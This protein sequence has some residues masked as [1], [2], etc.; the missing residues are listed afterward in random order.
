MKVKNSISDFFH[1][2]LRTTNTNLKILTAFTRALT[3]DTAFIDVV[4]SDGTTYKIPSLKGLYMQIKKLQ[5]Q[6]KLV[7][8]DEDKVFVNEPKIVNNVSVPLTFQ[9]EDNFLLKYLLRNYNITTRLNLTNIVS[10][11]SE[12]VN[13][14]RLIIKEDSKWDETIKKQFLGKNLDYPT[15]INSLN[16]L[17]ISY[18]IDENIFDLTPNNLKAS[19]TFLLT[20]AKSSYYKTA[21]FDYVRDYTISSNIYSDFTQGIIIPKI[22]LPGDK[23]YN[24]ET[25]DIY[26]I[27]A[28]KDKL[29]S[30]GVNY[31]L[32]GLVLGKTEFKVYTDIINE[33]FVDIPVDINE[34]QF[35]FMKEIT[36]KN[37]Q[38]PDWGTCVSFRSNRLSTEV[39]AGTT[40]MEFYKSSVYS[41]YEFLLNLEANGLQF[42]DHKTNPDA[43]TT[44]APNAPVLASATPLFKVVQINDFLQDEQ[45]VNTKS[46]NDLRATYQNLLTEITSIQKNLTKILADNPG[47]LSYSG[48]D[49]TKLAIKTQATNLQVKSSD[50]NT[51]KTE[52]ETK[53]QTTNTLTFSNVIGKK[54]R[55]NVRGMWPVPQR[56]VLNGIEQEII[57]FSIQYRYKSKTKHTMTFTSHE[58]TENGSTITGTYSNWS[59]MKTKMKSKVLNKST[60]KYEW[61]IENPG[62]SDEININ[63]LSLPINPGEA[64]D[65]RIK[66]ICETGYPIA[67]LESDWSDIVT[68]DFPADL[69]D[70]VNQ[71]ENF[72]LLQTTQLKLN[73]TVEEKLKDA[74]SLYASLAREVAN[75]NSFTPFALTSLVVNH[76]GG[77]SDF[78][79]HYGFYIQDPKTNEYLN[80]AKYNYR[81]LMSAVG[82][83][84]HVTFSENTHYTIS[85]SPSGNYVFTLNVANLVN[86]IDQTPFSHPAD[87]WTFYLQVFIDSK[88]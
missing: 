34:F 72:D 60:N 78:D 20:E 35:I 81:S 3:E 31:I 9:Y 32:D 36:R 17:N 63:Q 80:L 5:E 1:E 61:K 23:L 10:K 69:E 6:K 42:T 79:T 74:N 62:N 25:D 18:R 86:S 29:V 65:I 12:K 77:A 70:L 44:L 39:N 13:I 54:T 21:E 47:I 53:L 37:T 40:L 85:V 16:A 19:G 14:R 67:P 52:I 8:L 41:Y 45:K 4:L 48:S 33:K 50:L 75:L 28:I 66:T 84:G 64:I 2:I 71:Y 15:L 55:F 83:G 76:T 22:L 38:A 58:Y 57:Q 49:T 26:E 43:N 88:K 68:I 24:V 82:Y 11:F 87:N 56:K 30:L 73:Q 59:E 46:V 51:L 27:V 7:Y